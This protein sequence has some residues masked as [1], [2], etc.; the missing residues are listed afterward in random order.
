MKCPKCSYLGF[1]TGDR[2]KNCGYDFS[3]I[4]SSPPDDVEIDLTL[5]LPTTQTAMA[6]PSWA[7]EVDRALGAA[8]LAAR[9]A[10]LPA[11]TPEPMSIPAPAVA[12]P[13]APPSVAPPPVAALPLFMPVAAD[14]DD[15]PLIKLPATPRPP[16]AVRKTPEIPRLRAVP[17]PAPRTSAEPVLEF[18]DAAIEEEVAPAVSITPTPDADVFRPAHARA[19]GSTAAAEAGAP[20]ARLAAV[21]VDHLILVAID[22]SVIYLTL[23]MA[24]LGAGDWALL[25]LA[26]L[27]TFLVLLKVS[28]FCAFTA[29]GGQT[30]GKMAMGL[31]VVTD[32]GEPVDAARAIRRTL[33]GT[34]STAVLGLG[35]IPALIGSERRALHDHVAH[36]RVVDLHSA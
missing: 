19:A 11:K 21:A 27:A 36:T 16:L 14:D 2:C 1:E 9:E 17:R 25:P 33:A 7:E 13:A 15:A 31:R 23:R 6:T 5:E 26:P 4:D 35:F 8:A 29:I 10:E 12:P 22:A 34:V 20:G 32:D 18:A 30:I 24:Q 28:Y 3:L